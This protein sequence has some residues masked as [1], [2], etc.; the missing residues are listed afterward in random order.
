MVDNG[1]TVAITKTSAGAII[2][3]YT[4]GNQGSTVS[5]GASVDYY[6]NNT[7]AARTIAQISSATFTGTDFIIQTRD[8]ADGS[9][10]EKMRINGGSNVLIGSATDNS[11]TAKLQVTGGISY[12]NI[13]NRQTSSYTLV[14]TDQSKIVEMNVGSANNLTVPLNSSQAFPIGTEIQV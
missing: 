7:Q 5:T 2:Q 10:T 1:T 12:Q 4:T 6:L 13:F 14:L 11:T 3:G 8:T 9:L